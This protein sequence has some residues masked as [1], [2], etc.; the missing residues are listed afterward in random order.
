MPQ[1]HTGRRRVQGQ[2][3]HEIATQ[4]VTG[5][6]QRQHRETRGDV[7]GGVDHFLNPAG[8]ENARIE[9]MGIAVVAEVQPHHLE[10]VLQHVCGGHAHVARFGAALPTM[11]QQRHAGRHHARQPAVPGLQTHAV[12][13]VQHQLGSDR[14]RAG[15]QLLPATQ[16]HPAGGQHRLQV[17]I[18]Q[19]PRRPVIGG[20]Q[21]AVHA[22]PV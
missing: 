18:A 17:W 10:A 19:P 14:A 12:A 4:R 22:A 20:V 13:A 7:T 8:M 5:S 1:R 3:Q 16:P 15:Q 2:A 11:Q 6:H 9:V 21:H